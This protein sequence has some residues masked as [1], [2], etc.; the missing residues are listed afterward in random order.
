L[1]HHAAAVPQDL[2]VLLQQELGLH[3][4]IY[5][6]IWTAVEAMQRW[7][8]GVS[9]W[10][11]KVT[12]DTN[13]WLA[14]NAVLIASRTGP[15]T[16]GTVYCPVPLPLPIDLSQSL[17]PQQQQ[18][19][20]EDGQKAAA[21]TAA[22]GAAMG[23]FGAAVVITASRLRAD[24]G[25]K[26]PAAVA[27]MVTAAS[28]DSSAGS[29]PDHSPRAEHWAVLQRSDDGGDEAGGGLDPSHTQPHSTH[30]LPLQLIQ[31]SDSNAAAGSSS[32]RSP[33]GV[34]LHAR[35]LS[36]AVNHTFTA[37]GGGSNSSSTA[38]L[39]SLGH[40]RPQSAGRNQV[41]PV[42]AAKFAAVAASGA[43]PVPSSITRAAPAGI[44]GLVQPAFL[45]GQHPKIA[46]QHEPAGKE[47]EGVLGPEVQMLQQQQEEE[48]Q[49]SASE[50][51]ELCSGL[52]MADG[53]V[54]LPT[55]SGKAP[56]RHLQPMQQG[57]S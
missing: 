56:M 53:L 6:T 48:L 25:L 29:S 32:V 7:S 39:S 17:R 8:G 9:C 50:D 16:A 40:H 28:G 46:E 20:V 13:D 5:S 57:G 11:A 10:Q 44:M 18:K 36:C 12:A 43:S 37:A 1:L 23:E 35:T 52:G 49:G 54:R 51:E 38:S 42:D 27:G 2:Q 30:M 19:E 26:E 34:S 4:Q 24:A 55:I 45:V 22:V 15:G 14:E 41:L 47:V 33:G 3:A 31:H 21:A